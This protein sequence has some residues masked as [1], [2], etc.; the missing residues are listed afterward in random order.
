V[1]NH[2]AERAELAASSDV[3]ALLPTSSDQAFR[4]VIKV[5]LDEGEYEHAAAL[6][7]VLMLATGGR[8]R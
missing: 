2:V 1:H 4:L 5:A 7:D 8:A 6:L 3:V